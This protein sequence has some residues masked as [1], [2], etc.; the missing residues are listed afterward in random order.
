M[1]K[2]KKTLTEIEE[3]FKI[4]HPEMI[5]SQTNY[6]LLYESVGYD[7]SKGARPLS[8][9]TEEEAT[10]LCKLDLYCKYPE[11]VEVL[12]IEK[13]NLHYIDGE[14]ESGDGWSETQDKSVYFSS[15]T[16]RQTVYLLSRGFDL[17]GLIE[18]Q[19]AITKTTSPAKTK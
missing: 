3:E 8:D 18:K 5:V 14:I 11:E 15:M 17:F 19:L 9:M 4:N 2:E 12:R 6:E 10:E 16:P 1:N 7:L 13:S